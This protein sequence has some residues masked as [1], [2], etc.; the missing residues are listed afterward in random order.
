MQSVQEEDNVNQM[1]TGVYTCTYIGYFIY[2]HTYNTVLTRVLTK[3][4]V[5]Y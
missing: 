1:Y 4:V 3:Q 5:L 2:I